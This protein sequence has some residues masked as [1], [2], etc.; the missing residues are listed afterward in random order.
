[1]RLIELGHVDV[2][3]YGW[4]FYQFCVEQHLKEKD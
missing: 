4:Q 1:M 3:E 2:W